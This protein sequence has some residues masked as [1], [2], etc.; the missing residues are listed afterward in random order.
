MAAPSETSASTAYVPPEV[1]QPKDMGGTF[2]AIN[3][4]TAGAREE[5]A[6]P[7]GAHPLQLYSLATPNG[8]KV[9]ILLEELFD[10]YGVDYDAYTI[11]ITK[12]EQFGSGFVQV[13]PNSKIPCMM[14][15]STPDRPTRIF[16][17][18]SILMYLCEKYDTANKFL[19]AV[20]TPERVEVMN[21]VFWQMGS[22]PFLGGGFGHFYKYAPIKIEYAIDRFAMEVK[23][24]LDV[25]D[26]HFADGR[27]FFAGANATIA[28][29]AIY[30]W[31][32]GL[33]TK[34]LYAAQ[35]FLQVQDYQHVVAWAKRMES[36]PAVIRGKKVNNL[37]A[38]SP[39]D[40]LLERHSRADFDALPAPTPA[41]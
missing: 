3:R 6:L 15:Y 7:R 41:P 26:K 27:A 28:D 18:A 40:K 16:E 9:T 11:D 35:K 23:R 17:S 30:P 31:Y 29:F 5:K 25:L 20:G 10:A 4:P 19:P 14:D 8:V 21:W 37:W 38:S 32:G 2:G 22:A 34:D 36:R 1:W 24:Q 39:S 13:N 33:V 12:G